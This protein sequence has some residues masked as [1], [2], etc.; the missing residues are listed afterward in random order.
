MT[1]LVRGRILPEVEGTGRKKASLDVLACLSPPSAREIS[2]LDEVCILMQHLRSLG[3]YV[4]EIR[5]HVPDNCDATRL[6]LRQFGIPTSRVPVAKV[7]E[8]ERK[9]IGNDAPPALLEASATALHHDFDLILTHDQ[10]WFPFW[11][12]LDKYNLLAV[13]SGTL[14][15]QCEIFVRGHDVPWSFADMTWNHPWTTFYMMAERTTFSSGLRFLDTCQ[16]KK[17]DQD[18]S[19]TAR[20][21]VYNRLPSLCFTRDR[22]LFFELQ[23]RAAKR[24]GWARQNFQFE[25]GYHLE[26]YYLLIFGGLDSLAVLVNY[27]LKL[28]VKLRRVSAQSPIFLQALSRIAP[29]IHAAFT[30]PAFSGFLGRVSSLR[31][32]AAHRGSIMP[33]PVYEK[34]DVEPTSE[35]L[36]KEIREQGLDRRIEIF[37]PGPLRDWAREHE[38]FRMRLS[39]SKKLLDEVL[40]VEINGKYGFIHPM[41]DI[42]WN[43]D[44]FHNFANKVLDACRVRI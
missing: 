15:R 37:P 25:I 10:D 24:R 16:R 32:Q 44:K 23:R 40:L 18:T 31:H 35:E 38:R 39:K 27:A 33:G 8:N 9:V 14:K 42:E 3:Q 29:E 26:F 41:S 21:L 17:V 12:E 22:L 20:M 11:H 1:P 19:E 6:A 13:D 4:C 34:F 7:T 28:G 2:D 5:L 36:D 30:D 43:F